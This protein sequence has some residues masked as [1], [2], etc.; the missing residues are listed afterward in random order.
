MVTLMSCGL[1]H[2]TLPAADLHI[3]CRDLPDPSPIVHGA[4]G[5]DDGVGQIIT[6]SNPMV[7]SWIDLAAVAAKQLDALVDRPLVVF[8]C[9]AGMHRS[10]F[11]T[12]AVAEVLT[13]AGVTVDVVH[14]DLG[15]SP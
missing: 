3:D 7:N 10:V 4:N 6:E 14:R 8:Y 1:N 11:A 2:G 13:V 5:L 12:R 15:G 9:N